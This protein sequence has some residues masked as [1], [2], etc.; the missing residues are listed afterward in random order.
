MI[1]HEAQRTFVIGFMLAS[2]CTCFVV[3]ILLME[4]CPSDP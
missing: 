4:F 2:G 3:E 1:F